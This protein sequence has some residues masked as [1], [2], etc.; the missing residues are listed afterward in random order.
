[1]RENAG[2]YRSKAW[3]TPSLYINTVRKHAD[4]WPHTLRLQAE[5]ADR[6]HDTTPENLGGEYQESGLDIGRLPGPNGGW[7]VGWTDPGEWIEFPGVQLGCGIHRFTAR[8]SS[9]GDGNRIRLDLPT[10]SSTAISNTGF[11]QYENAH[12][13]EVRMEAGEYAL[14]IVFETGSV[15]ID[16]LF[17]KKAIS[18]DGGGY[19][20]LV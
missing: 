8:C 13:G 3:S 1:M 7:H 4:P 10:L 16:W 19:V 9:E 20:H 11:T 6:F 15:N 5:T 17:I 12:L 14:R 18:C 2:Y